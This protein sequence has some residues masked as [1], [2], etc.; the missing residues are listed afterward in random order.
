MARRPPIVNVMAKAAYRAARGL[1]RDFG[2]V[3]HLQVSEK[4]PSDFV[5]SADTRAERVLYEELSAAHPDYG[6]LME[7]AGR[8][9]NLKSDKRWIVDPLDG[10]LNFLHALPHFAISIGFEEKGEVTAGIVLDPV[11]DELF[12][13]AKGLGC[14]VNDKR[15]RVSSRRKMDAAL[16]ATGIPWAGR[17]DHDEFSRKLSAVMPKV[18]GVRRFGVAALDLAYVAAGRFEGFWETGLLPWDMA[19]GILLVTE[20]GGLVSD[21]KGA[22]A[23]LATGGI[24]AANAALFDE[25]FALLKDPA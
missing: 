13:A 11:K 12:W 18:A 21:M 10:T 20:A 19:A 3:E 16:L 7:E 2:E 25:L 15:L 22:K 1:L 5:T 8:K 9:G 17:K 14:H 23:M 6:F 24:L 4:G